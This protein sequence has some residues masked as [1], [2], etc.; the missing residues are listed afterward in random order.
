MQLKFQYQ[1]TPGLQRVVSPENSVLKYIS[2]H[3]LSLAPG[4]SYTGN[5]SG[6]ELALVIITGTCSVKVANQHYENIG[7]RKTVFDSPAYTVY[8][9]CQ[10]DYTITA[11]NTPVEVAVGGVVSDRPGEPV[12]I[13][14]QMVSYAPRGIWHWRRHIYDVMTH[15]NPVS[16]RLIIIEV[17]T[18]PGHWSSVPPHKHDVD[19]PPYESNVEEIYFYKMKP[20]HG[21]GF[22]RVY[23]DDRSLDE[24]LVVEHNC[25][26][27]QPKGYHP[28]ANHPG[29]QMYYL[30]ILGGEKR[31]LLPY[32]DPQHAWV[33]DVEQVIK[34][35]E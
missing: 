16:H 10:T 11:G 14:P 33:K 17:I 35:R 20:E 2:L 3:V 34:V 21:F 30:N 28:V 5:S 29:Y 12:L 18:P 15:I 19:N 13:T 23:T 8:V 1:P 27:I 6:E 31:A 24:A 7:G 32:D 4:E 25:A 22:Q 26:T 9:P